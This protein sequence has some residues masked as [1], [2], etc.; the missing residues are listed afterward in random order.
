MALAYTPSS[1]SNKTLPTFRLLGVD[2]NYYQDTSFNEKILVIM[3]ICNHCPYVR[4]LE[5]RIIEIVNFFNGKD[6]RF[7]GVCS[8]DP[9][10]YPEDSFENLKKRA[11]DKKYGFLYLSDARAQLAQKCEAVCTPDF[12]IYNK[13]RKQ[14]WRGRFDDSTDDPKNIQKEEMKLA[15]ESLLKDQKPEVEQPSKGCSIKWPT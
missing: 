15:I 13:D 9:Q 1:D 14:S 6:V 12:F 10:T 4:I 8:N 5:D 7:L 11:R 3:F 2:G